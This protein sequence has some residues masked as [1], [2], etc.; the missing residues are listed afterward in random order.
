MK[1]RGE[2]YLGKLCKYADRCSVYQ[3]SYSG[4][5]TPIHIIKNV[6]CNR[7]IRGWENCQRYRLYEQ[8]EDV[9][10]DLPPQS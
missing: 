5:S 9:A 6:F 3:E 10:P 8:G 4:F 7:G 1:K 2:R